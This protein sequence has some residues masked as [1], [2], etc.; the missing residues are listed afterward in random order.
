[1]NVD[2]KYPE[3][4][5]WEQVL[6]N[7]RQRERGNP[8]LARFGEAGLCVW[9]RILGGLDDVGIHPSLKAWKR[10]TIVNPWELVPKLR[11]AP[12]GYW[13]EQFPDD[14]RNS[15]SLNFNKLVNDRREYQRNRRVLS[16][17]R[18][19]PINSIFVGLRMPDNSIVL[20]EGHHQAIA[21][22]LARDQGL[23][24]NL[25]ELKIDIARH[26]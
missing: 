8:D 19:F 12:Y 6:D 4:V 10:Y 7:W 16:I 22:T 23:L 17:M 14:I 26:P 1:M 20:L 25:G 2:L 13:Q 9:E 18:D 3:D 11:L 21:I 24:L 15:V 5:T